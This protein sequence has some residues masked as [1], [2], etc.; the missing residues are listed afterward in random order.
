MRNY[1]PEGRGNDGPWKARKTKIRFP[2]LS[3]ALGNR[4]RFPHSHR[5]CGLSSI[6]NENREPRTLERSPYLVPA[7]PAPSRLIFRLENAQ[8]PPSRLVQGR[9]ASP[10][11]R[12]NGAQ[13]IGTCKFAED[14]SVASGCC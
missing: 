7:I 13:G 4:K 12:P 6:P 11:A 3:T 1:I 2:S 14:N 5:L 9:R 8:P 10:D